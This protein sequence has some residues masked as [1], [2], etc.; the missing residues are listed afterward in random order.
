MLSKL[1]KEIEKI[2]MSEEKYFNCVTEVAS[3]I[4]TIKEPML[5]L[6]IVQLIALL[7]KK[8][9]EAFKNRQK[10]DE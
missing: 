1:I 6:Q 3:R 5:Q 8:Q 9:Q 4:S 7:D 10:D 2:K